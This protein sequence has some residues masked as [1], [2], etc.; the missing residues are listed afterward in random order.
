M[1]TAVETAL[2]KFFDALLG[3][4]A[5]PSESLNDAF[6][7]IDRDIMALDDASPA[8]FLKV[9]GNP[10]LRH[11][12]TEIGGAFLTAGTDFHKGE[13]VGGVIN[14]LIGL[15]FPGGGAAGIQTDLQ[16]ADHKLGTS[17]TDLMTF[18][19]EFAKIDTSRTL[20]QFNIKIAGLADGSVT[21]ANDMTADHDAY[22]KLSADFLNLGGDANLLLPA[23]FKELGG[24]LQKL[25]NDFATLA[26][27]F[28]NLDGALV[29]YQTGGSGTPADPNAAGGGGGSG[30]PLGNAL[31]TLFQ[32]FHALGADTG[33]V[34][35][36]SA[37]LI[38]DLIQQSVGANA[39]HP[40]DHGTH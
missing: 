19:G 21:L 17:S 6:H 24:D 9:E 3:R 13:M 38:S 31:A 34:A 33:V 35:H 8:N 26:T 1:P 36:E 39:N 32:D 11:D 23:V 5:P 27:D 25:A 2:E 22:Q 28:R 12:F 16:S 40:N 14:G 18:G 10:G 20:D 30:K 29:G 4:N 37:V 7:K 15:L